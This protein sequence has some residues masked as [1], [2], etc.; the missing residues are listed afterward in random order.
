MIFIYSFYNRG[1]NKGAKI[2]KICHKVWHVDLW[3]QVHRVNK[4]QTRRYFPHQCIST[5]KMYKISFLSSWKFQLC[6]RSVS[7][8]FQ[9]F[10]VISPHV[11]VCVVSITDTPL[12]LS[13]R[14]NEVSDRTVI[15]FPIPH[16]QGISHLW[17]STAVL[18]GIKMQRMHTITNLT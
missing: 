14:L 10:C 12:N 15:F 11:S 7:G 8:E 1:H 18:D 17:G 13:N 9:K 16:P 5:V 3:A 6:V 2:F 4:K